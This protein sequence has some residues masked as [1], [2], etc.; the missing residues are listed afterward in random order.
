MDEPV[1]TTGSRAGEQDLAAGRERA[2]RGRA[3]AGHVTTHK[4]HKIKTDGHGREIGLAGA[5]VAMAAVGARLVLHAGHRETMLSAAADST[6][7]YRRPD[8][9]ARAVGAASRKATESRRSRRPS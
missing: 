9:P 3:K 1:P 4:I 2:P 7:P 5:S 8:V 6:R